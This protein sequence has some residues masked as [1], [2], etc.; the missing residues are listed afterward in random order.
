MD[1]DDILYGNVSA[2]IWSKLDLMNSHIS[3]IDLSRFNFSKKKELRFIF[4]AF[5]ACPLML[6]IFQINIFVFTSLF[7][8]SVMSESI[9]L[10][11]GVQ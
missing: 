7:I 11:H 10:Y 3:V 2:S 9:I 6:P 1:E 8:M 5:S 4:L